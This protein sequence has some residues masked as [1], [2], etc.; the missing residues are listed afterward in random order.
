MSATKIIAID[1]KKHTIWLGIQLSRAATG[2]DTDALHRVLSD[3]GIK[4]GDILT[5][6]SGRLGKTF[7]QISVAIT[8][9]A[10]VFALPEKYEIFKSAKLAIEQIVVGKAVAGFQAK[11]L[12]CGDLAITQLFQKS[13]GEA[14]NVG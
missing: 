3:Y 2:K 13:K 10:H 4:H 7:D 14:V 6:P 8:Y 11:R 5:A 12:F 1:E 9:P